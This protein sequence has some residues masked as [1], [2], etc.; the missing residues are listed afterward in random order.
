MISN[1]ISRREM[2]FFDLAKAT[3]RTSNYHGQHL[4]CCVVYK[5]VVISVAP[6]CERTHPL[7]ASYNRFRDFDPRFAQNKLHAEV[8]ALSLAMKNK[9]IDWSKVSIYVYREFKNGTPAI[10]KPCSACSQLIQ[11]L[12]IHNMY[13]IDANGRYVKETI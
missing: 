4:G 12:G 3:A 13:Y 2:R 1:N 5:G 11:D 7:Q 10:S 9:R 8:H 6:N